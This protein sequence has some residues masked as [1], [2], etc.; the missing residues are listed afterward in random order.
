MTSAFT[1]KAIHKFLQDVITKGMR[2]MQD[3]PETFKF[4]KIDKWDGKDVNTHNENDWMIA[5]EL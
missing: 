4:T 5:E 2:G 1:A 3:L